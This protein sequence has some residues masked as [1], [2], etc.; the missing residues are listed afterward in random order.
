MVEW[1]FSY[2]SSLEWVKAITTWEQSILSFWIT[3]ACLILGLLLLILPTAYILQ[4]ICRTFIFAFLGPWRRLY[5]EL[6]ACLSSLRRT[7]KIKGGNKV[8]AQNN[9]DAKSEKNMKFEKLL[10]KFEHDAQITR[11]VGEEEIKRKAMRILQFGRFITRVPSVNLARHY[12]YPMKKSTAVRVACDSSPTGGGRKVLLPPQRLFGS[13]IPKN[14]NSELDGVDNLI[15]DGGFPS[16]RRVT[17]LDDIPDS[18]IEVQDSFVEI[19]KQTK[20]D[21]AEE[22]EKRTSEDDI[23]QL[24]GLLSFQNPLKGFY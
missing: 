6:A 23:F 8:G 21:E 11:L 3:L 24:M 15:G 10:K 2:C 19:Q 5:V 18:S 7:C 16:M 20:D 4:C 1:A 12:D 13:M 9:K 17:I 22:E 14:N